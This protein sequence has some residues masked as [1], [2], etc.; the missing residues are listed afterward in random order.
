MDTGDRERG[1]RLVRRPAELAGNHHALDSPR[2]VPERAR[3]LDRRAR[4]V[5]RKGILVEEKCAMVLG[6]NVE[7]L[8]QG[9]VGDKARTLL[10][11]DHMP[12]AN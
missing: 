1:P 6:D 3:D 12:R 9:N 2:R 5:A 10:Y 11:A 7:V 8:L 4:V